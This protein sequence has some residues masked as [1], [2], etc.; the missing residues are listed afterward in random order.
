VTR[1]IDRGFDFV[2]PSYRRGGS[3]KE[4]GRGK[5]VYHEIEIFQ[6]GIDERRP[7]PSEELLGEIPVRR[8]KEPGGFVAQDG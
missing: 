1:S 8:Y 7:L 2:R 6:P 5:G 3:Y 4:G